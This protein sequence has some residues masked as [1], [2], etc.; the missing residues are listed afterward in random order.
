MFLS[1][2]LALLQQPTFLPLSSAVHGMN[3][4][5]AE[6]R[7]SSRHGDVVI[8]TVAVAGGSV[9]VKW[10]SNQVAQPLLIPLPFVSGQAAACDS[11]GEWIVGTLRD[12]LGNESAVIWSPHFGALLPLMNQGSGFSAISADHSYAAGHMIDASGLEVPLR[13]STSTGAIDVILDGAGSISRGRA[14]A[15]SGNGSVV[16][17]YFA[18][19][20]GR[21]RPFVWSATHGTSTV[22]PPAGFSGFGK[23]VALSASGQVV[24]GV[25]EDVSST[26]LRYRGFGASYSVTTGTATVF[27][28]YV[29][30]VPGMDNIDARSVDGIGVEPVGSMWGPSGQ[31]AFM[32]HSLLFLF[33][34]L[35]EYLELARGVP[36]PPGWTLLAATAKSADGRIIVGNGIDPFGAPRGWWASLGPA[37]TTGA[38][39]CGDSPVNSIGYVANLYFGNLASQGT[40]NL[41]T[42][43][44]PSGFGYYVASGTAM[45]P[46]VPPGSRGHLCLGGT[47]L[48]LALPQQIRF[49]GGWNASLQTSQ[50]PAPLHAASSGA[51]WHFQYWYRDVE[52]GSATS[53]FSNALTVI[54]Q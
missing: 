15:I 29:S 48:R 16:V 27:A 51:A 50:L 45:P 26:G 8:G 7:A 41:D 49:S 14:L 12:G 11:E 13:V 43:F 38:Q 44:L 19:A 17:G 40:L 54:V 30:S 53:R 9:P 18:N 32:H 28:Q 20:H 3:G 33:P 6:P 46:T 23:A 10:I 42:N 2:T 39:F 1:I 25:L 22:D 36:I 4:I 31:A 5:G 47:V 24:L 21:S 34:T 35:Q 52:S 37:A